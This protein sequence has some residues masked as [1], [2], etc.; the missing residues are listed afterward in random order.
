MG[1][2]DFAFKDNS[3]EPSRVGF[4][5]I[6]AT[7][8]NIDALNANIDI[9]EAALLGVTLG[10]LNTITLKAS[11]ENLTSAA[12]TNV[13]AQRENKWDVT[14]IGADTGNVYHRQIPCADLS[15]LQTG[16][17][18]MIAGAA[19]T[20]LEDAIEGIF[21]TPDDPNGGTVQSIKFKAT[22]S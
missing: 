5:V 9:L 14:I 1:Q 10:A 12:A 2:V 4:P 8:A 11:V 20:A 7:S 16:T 6:D 13:L 17:E 21:W 22:N 18:D 15:L 19:R 3:S